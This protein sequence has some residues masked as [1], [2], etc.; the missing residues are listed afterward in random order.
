MTSRPFGS[1][2]SDPDFFNDEDIDDHFDSLETAQE[3]VFYI[4]LYPYKFLNPTN[5]NFFD[6]CSLLL[7]ALDSETKEKQ[8]SLFAAAL[9]TLRYEIVTARHYYV[10]DLLLSKFPYTQKVAAEYL[11]ARRISEED[12]R[13]M[14][15]VIETRKEAETRAKL[16]AAK[17]A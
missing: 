9:T 14:S 10:A 7:S 3:K 11:L 4:I 5:P 1:S 17:Q 13:D 8:G 2:P 12:L 16:E 15:S 6:N